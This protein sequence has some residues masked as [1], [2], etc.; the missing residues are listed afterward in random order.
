M[1][2]RAPRLLI[3]SIHFLVAEQ[4]ILDQ[5]RSR[6]LSADFEPGPAAKW[7]ATSG[8]GDILY[9]GTGEL[10]GELDGVGADFHLALVEVLAR[11]V[12]GQA[13][14]LKGQRQELH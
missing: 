1:S 8:L 11:L 13:G 5:Q 2:P 14:N 4:A 12:P 10:V 6:P 9:Q 3:S 7:S